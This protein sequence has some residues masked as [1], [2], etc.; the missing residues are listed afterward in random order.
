MVRIN[1]ISDIGGA[2]ALFCSVAAEDGMFFKPLSLPAFTD[3]FFGENRET[4]AAY[5]DGICIGF[6]AGTVSP[7]RSVSYI[8]FICVNKS[9]RRTGI[10]GEL[11]SALERRLYRPESIKTDIVF[12]NPVGLEWFIP[13]GNGDSHP[14]APGVDVSSDA[15]IFFKNRGYRDFAVQN[16]Y[17][18][19]LDGYLEPLSCAASRKRLEE[20]G[21]T[22]TLYS[23][24]RHHGLAELFDD[25]GNPGWRVHVLANTDKP[26]I[27]AADEN[28][29]G[30]VVAYTGPLTVDASGRGGFC[31][32]GTLNAY[33]GRGIGKLVFAEM[34][35][36]HSLSGAT[37]MSLYTGETN[38][39]RNIYEAAGFR[40][41]RTFAN[42][43]KMIK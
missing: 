32:I 6:A 23:P 11:L 9:Y 7:E 35:R 28:A 20:S 5:D 41:V 8:S 24:A 1:D 12:H 22:L 27:V 31:G 40:I 43:R 26:I 14:Y 17:Y 25:I 37:Y 36:R 33:R 13:N 16:A 38:N 29:G 3:K 21:I 19:R 10:G 15:Y 34:C 42:M 30:L 4:V 39:A 2:A 18:M